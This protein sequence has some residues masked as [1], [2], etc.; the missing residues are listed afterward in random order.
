MTLNSIV[1][2]T[3]SDNIEQSPVNNVDIDGDEMLV[4][5]DEFS[6][7]E[8]SSYGD[9]PLTTILLE[10][11]QQT[12][13]RLYRLAFKIRNPAMRLGLSK[14]S[15][16]RELDPETGVDL[17]D[18]YANIDQRHMLEILA[19][20]QGKPVDNLQNHYLVHRLAKANTRRRQ[21]YLYWRKRDSKL[22]SYSR[23]ETEGMHTE[24]ANGVA[25][26]EM[27]GVGRI[28]L[29]ASQPAP[30]RPST[31]TLL[32]QNK[33][34]LDDDVSMISSSTVFT[35]RQTENNDQV[36]IPKPPEKYW[37]QKEFKCPFCYTLCPRKL[38]AQK[39][40]E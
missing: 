31:A 32:D 23:P 26:A 29:N 13:D 6:S 10:N 17:V 19:S 25:P 36:C 30:S 4:S 3:L 21:Q 7:D 40:W 34:N 28:Q 24:N 8:D 33:V 22:E 9:L 39:A 2:G 35:E 15:R 38:L 5:E 1:L 11:A 20:Y 37:D 12:I 27:K 18:Q 14:A 16:H